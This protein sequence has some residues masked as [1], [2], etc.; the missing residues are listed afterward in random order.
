MEKYNENS[1]CPKCKNE[2][3]DTI[4]NQYF[5][6][7]QRRCNRCGHTWSEH[8]LDEMNTTEEIITKFK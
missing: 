1:M 2:S 5:N 4:Y 3:V 7:M 6:M 8:P